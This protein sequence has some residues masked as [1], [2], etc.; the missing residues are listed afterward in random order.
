MPNCQEK[1]ESVT[2]KYVWFIGQW[3]GPWRWLYNPRTKVWI[4][5]FIE[6]F[7]Q[8]YWT[9]R[10]CSFSSEFVHFSASMLKI[11]L[12]LCRSVSVSCVYLHASCAARILLWH[13]IPSLAFT[14]AQRV[15]D[16]W[17][18]P[19]ASSWSS[20]A[21]NLI[22]FLSRRLRIRIGWREGGCDGG[23]P[24]LA[25]PFPLALLAHPLQTC[26]PNQSAPPGQT[27]A[28]VC[29][30]SHFLAIWKSEQWRSLPPCSKFAFM[31]K[32]QKF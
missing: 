23:G 15:I 18:K 4:Q 2:A 25:P 20:F 24:P 7:Q 27:F 22:P 10:G 6:Q 30:P 29:T 8:W 17:A 5:S 16:V 31:H 14:A 11:W 26:L 13:S 1:G 32:L 19:S 28:Y 12:Q 21:Q 9:H 3:A